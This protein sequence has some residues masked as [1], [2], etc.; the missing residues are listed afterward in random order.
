MSNVDALKYNLKSKIIMAMEVP[1][2]NLILTKGVDL[3]PEMVAKAIRER[4]KGAIKGSEP[5]VRVCMKKGKKKEGFS[6]SVSETDFIHETFNEEPFPLDEY[7]SMEF[8]SG[9][10]KKNSPI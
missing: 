2:E 1:M 8:L 5:Y 9:V 6:I 10:I 4:Y 3:T 7:D